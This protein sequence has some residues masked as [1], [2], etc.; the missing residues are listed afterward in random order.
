MT[1]QIQM[2][3]SPNASEAKLKT[4]IEFKHLQDE[5]ETLEQ[6]MVQESTIFDDQSNA[7]YDTQREQH[8]EAVVTFKY[9][10]SHIAFSFGQHQN[11]KQN[12]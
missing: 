11:W 9:P 10:S 7:Q 3:T 4:K 12:C 5:V 6:S 2:P 1:S 8:K